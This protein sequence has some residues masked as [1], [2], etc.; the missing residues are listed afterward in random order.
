MAV[1]AATV[2]CPECG[3]A[4]EGRW[5]VTGDVED[6]V[7][8]PEAEQECPG[9]HRFSEEFPGWSHYVEAG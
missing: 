1:L 9:G 7:E 4:F 6:M 5:L 3:T 8:P 2:D